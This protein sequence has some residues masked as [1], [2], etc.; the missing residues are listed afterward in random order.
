MAGC[1]WHGSAHLSS[2]SYCRRAKRISVRVKRQMDRANRRATP[3]RP[4]PTEAFY[5]DH[6]ERSTAADVHAILRTIMKEFGR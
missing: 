3:N 6:P 5:T 1:P 2:C 4:P